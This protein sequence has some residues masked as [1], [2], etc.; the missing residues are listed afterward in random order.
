MPF[1]ATTRFA[2]TPLI[3]KKM[4]FITDQGLYC[5]K[6]MPFGLKNV[7]ATFQRLMK[8]MFHEQIERNMEVYV[9]DILVKSVLPIDHID[10]L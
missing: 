2:C 6:V 1:L 9:D 7:G 8:K 5:Y 3:R 10:D 4:A